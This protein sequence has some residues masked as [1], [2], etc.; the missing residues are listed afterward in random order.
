MYNKMI[1][2]YPRVNP[3]K[4]TFSFSNYEGSNKNKLLNE[5]EC[6]LS[7]G[8]AEK[9][10]SLRSGT[11]YLIHCSEIAYW[12]TTKEKKPDDL[13]KSLT[14]TVPAG[15]PYTFI[16]EESTANGVGNYFHANY[17]HSKDG[18][19]SYTPFFASW[20]E[21]EHNVMPIND[22]PKFIKSLNLNEQLMWEKGAS[23]EGLKWYRFKLASKSGDLWGM[24]SE[25]PSDDIEA[26]QSTGKRVF[27]QDYV[28]NLRRSNRPPLYVGDIFPN[29]ARGE[30]ALKNV[31]FHPYAGG[32][33][34][35]WALPDTSN[36]SDRYVVALD[37]GGKREGA[38]WCIIKVID[39]YWQIDGGNPETVFTWRGHL[40]ADLVAWKGIQIAK[41]YNDALFCP[42]DNSIERK[43]ST[44]GDHFLTVIDEIKDIYDNI[45]CRTP[46]EKVI[47][48]VPAQYGFWTGTKNKGMI[49]DNFIACAREME[50]TERDSRVC[51]EMDQYELKPNGTM[52][53]VAGAHDD[54]LM[55][56]AI[57]LWLA[58]SYMEKPVEITKKITKIRRPMRVEDVI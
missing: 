9:P 21:Y 52:G 47:E 55:A 57:G 20:F 54:L 4:P 48:G 3:D 36:V 31:E 43:E 2:K 27:P 46:I 13:I 50:F 17:Q 53:A 1:R 19:S 5:R 6:V 37:I 34:F 8:S 29:G 26:F 56:T 51:D 10:D 15:E 39:R 40:D 49:I 32:N 14:E 28:N 58:I 44:E 35:V 24:R 23:L 22:Y 11:N 7:I 41:F 18:T 42:E 16:I 30:A 12:P 25:N 38:D 33:A 45:Y